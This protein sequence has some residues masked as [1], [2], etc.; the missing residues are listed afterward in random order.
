MAG[1]SGDLVYMDVPAVRDMAKKFGQIGE[2]LTN[3]GKVLEQLSNMCNVA[4]FIGLIGAQVVKAYI[5]QLRPHITKLAKK[6]QELNK[7][8]MDSAAAYERGDQLGSA[9][10]H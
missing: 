7:D 9:R 4:A 6:C 1:G 5:D 8:I 3:V 2:V 10:F